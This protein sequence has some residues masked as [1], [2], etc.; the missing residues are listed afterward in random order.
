MENPAIILRLQY[1][2]RNNSTWIKW[3]KSIRTKLE[4]LVE[5][6][7]LIQSIRYPNTRAK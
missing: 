2:V 5:L 1:D 7:L 3:V 4:Q 6:F